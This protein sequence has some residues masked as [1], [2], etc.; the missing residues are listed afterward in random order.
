MIKTFRNKAL[1]RFFETG[2]ARDLS[3]QDDKR[4]ARILR[5]LEA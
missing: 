2:K 3:V 1:Q 4:V 5:A